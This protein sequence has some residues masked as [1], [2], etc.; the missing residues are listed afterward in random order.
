VCKGLTGISNHII[1]SGHTIST[2]VTLKNHRLSGREYLLLN[3]SRHWVARTHFSNKNN[4]N[5]NVPL[6]AT[7]CLLLTSCFAT[8]VDTVYEERVSESYVFMNFEA[9]ENLGDDLIY[10]DENLQIKYAVRNRE[11][12]FTIENTSN[13]PIYIDMAR[14]SLIINKQAYNYLKTLDSPDRFYYIPSKSILPL[15]D[16]KS[17][18]LCLSVCFPKVVPSV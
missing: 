5:T 12:S 15:L 2:T 17:Y 16:F 10:K 4:M 3:L 9:S 14:S 18:I 11:Y 8:K 1:D 6:L 7:I 13:N